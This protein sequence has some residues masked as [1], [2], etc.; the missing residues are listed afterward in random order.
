M[1]FMKEN[2]ANTDLPV[3]DEA[4]SSMVRSRRHFEELIEEGGFGILSHEY[5]EEFPEELYKVSIWALRRK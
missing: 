4:D 5:Q 1:I 3:F 2:V